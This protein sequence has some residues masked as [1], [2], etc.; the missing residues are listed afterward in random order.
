MYMKYIKPKVI[1]K[2][3]NSNVDVKSALVGQF[4]AGKVFL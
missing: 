4:P 3:D 2:K 1:S